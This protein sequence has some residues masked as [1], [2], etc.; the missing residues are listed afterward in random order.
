MILVKTVRFRALN[1]L[2]TLVLAEARGHRRC[3]LTDILKI[4]RLLETRLQKMFASMIGKR[5]SVADVL[6]DRGRVR[7]ASNG[8]NFV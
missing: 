1:Y 3:R 5:I 4:S 8:H 6:H 7:V 2:T